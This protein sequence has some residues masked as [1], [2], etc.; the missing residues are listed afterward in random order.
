MGALV[1]YGWD[2]VVIEDVN[3]LGTEVESL[4]MIV[5]G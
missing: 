5:V 1:L 2:E 3:R 4:V